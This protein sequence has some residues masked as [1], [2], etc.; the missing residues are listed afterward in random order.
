MNTQ[1]V[2]RRIAK[3]TSWRIISMAL[4][5]TAAWYLTGNLVVVMGLAVVEIVKFVLFMVHDHVWSGISLGK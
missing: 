2:H 5:A 1:V 3:S 4:T